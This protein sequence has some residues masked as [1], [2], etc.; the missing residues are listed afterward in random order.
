M[1]L[2][3]LLPLI[4]LASAASIFSRSTLQV[5][6]PYP[7]PTDCVPLSCHNNSTVIC[8]STTNKQACQDSSLS[9][10]DLGRACSN[11]TY[12]PTYPLTNYCV[13]ILAPYDQSQI[14][15]DCSLTECADWDG[16]PKALWCL[17]FH[18]TGMDWRRLQMQC[19]PSA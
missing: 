5:I 6:P 12:S 11:E 10:T 1:Y 19:A 7:L 17:Y 13:D 9:L 15:K 16:E 4:P 18:V 3:T 14:P 8:S 2:A